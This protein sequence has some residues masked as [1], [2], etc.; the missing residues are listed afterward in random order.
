[1]GSC[2]YYAF[3]DRIQTEDMNLC[4]FAS[5]E[6]PFIVNCAGNVVTPFAFTTDNFWG[7]EDHYLIYMVKGSMDVMF[8]E[9]V[10]R[11][12]AGNVIIFP[13]RYHYR[14]AYRGEEPLSY[15]WVHFTGSYA[16]RFLGECNLSPL[17]YIHDTGCDNGIAAGF[18]RMFDIFEGQSP[19][20]RQEL[21]CALEQLLLK[22]AASVG[23]CGHDRS[24]ERS[25][26]YIHSFYNTDIRIPELAK[27][28]NLS[29]SRYI[30]LFNRRMRMSPTAY[31]IKLRMSIACDLLQKTDMSVKQIGILVGYEDAHFFSKLFKKHMGVAPQNYRKDVN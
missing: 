25:V 21:S 16:E 23:E 1:M 26:R 9:G 12:G 29:N 20:K 10:R 11:V 8:P 31:I 6:H 3:D 15:L 7:R 24:L 19:L 27:M 28:E 4:N 17:P 5:D 13:P 14:Y 2:R 18:R 22:V 30:T